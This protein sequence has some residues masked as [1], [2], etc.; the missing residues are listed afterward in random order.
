M[1]LPTTFS[2]AV[3]TRTRPSLFA[4]VTYH[5]RTLVPPH[6]ICNQELTRCLIGTYSMPS[7]HVEEMY[8]VEN[9]SDS[10]TA[11]VIIE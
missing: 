1:R 5:N 4:K 7:C 6:S 3:N 2:I 10:E 8:N 9:F 11:T